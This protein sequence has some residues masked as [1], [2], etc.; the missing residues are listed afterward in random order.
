MDKRVALGFILTLAIV[1]IVPAYQFAE[2]GRMSAT[3]SRFR[4]ESASRG[5]KLYADYCAACHGAKGEGTTAPALNAKE[6]LGRAKDEV[7]FDLTRTGIP[8]TAMPAWG[9]AH[10][11]PLT[12]EQVRDIVA[13][14]RSWE[15]R[16]QERLAPGARGNPASGSA[17]YFST[18]VACHGPEGEG[19]LTVS[20]ALNDPRLQATHDDKWFYDVISRGRLD[21]GMPTW[22]KVLS[23]A[24]I[25]DVIAYIR[26]WQTKPPASK[27]VVE[28]DAVKGASLYSVTCTIC[29]GT[30]GS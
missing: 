17:V 23:P 15:P 24:Q 2:P 22:G 13:F 1:L 8:N 25:N 19:T 12:D 11:G 14:V 9:Q 26:T 3:M 30:T 7:I 10:G 28:G 5:E 20:V 4:A 27:P 16:A 6:F 18:C 29:H 21:K